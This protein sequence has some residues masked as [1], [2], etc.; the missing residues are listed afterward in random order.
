MIKFEHLAFTS[1]YWGFYKLRVVSW[2]FVFD[3]CKWLGGFWLIIEP[4]SFFSDDFETFIKPK[5]IWL[6]IASLAITVFQNRPRLKFKYFI[7]CI[8]IFNIKIKNQYKDYLVIN[9]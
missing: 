3:I 2:N 5:G 9:I 4:I 8:L 6:F 1:R 7:T